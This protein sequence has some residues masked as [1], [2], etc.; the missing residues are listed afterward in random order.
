MKNDVRKAFTAALAV[1]AALTGTALVS[2]NATL[3]HPQQKTAKTTNAYAPALK[4]AMPRQ[5]DK[6]GYWE[7]I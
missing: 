3:A 1:T 2:G 4:P 5:K 6:E 7:E